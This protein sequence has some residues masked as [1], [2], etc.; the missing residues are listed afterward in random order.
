[1]EK[2]LPLARTQMSLT[3]V[4]IKKGRGPSHKM[5]NVELVRTAK[6]VP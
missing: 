2:G 5:Q 3:M 6:D 1:M 4:R